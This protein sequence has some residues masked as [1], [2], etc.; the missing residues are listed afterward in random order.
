MPKKRKVAPISQ[1]DH[2]EADNSLYDPQWDAS[3]SSKSF[4]PYAFLSKYFVKQSF[5][6][7]RSTQD[8]S[9]LAGCT[10]TQQ[11]LRPLHRCL[12][13]AK[14]SV[15]E[16]DILADEIRYPRCMK[17]EKVKKFVELV[18]RIQ[19]TMGLSGNALLIQ[20]FSRRRIDP[21]AE[22]TAM[23][24]VIGVYSM[25]ELAFAQRKN[26]V[27]HCLA[28]RDLRLPGYP[29]T[30]NTDIIVLMSI[31]SNWWPCFEDVANPWV[32]CF[33][34]T[35]VDIVTFICLVEA[36][37]SQQERVARKLSLA[38]CSAQ[39]QRRA[40][41][42]PDGPVYGVTLCGFQITMF[43]ATWE[44]NNFTSEDNITHVLS[45]NVLKH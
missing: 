29:W 15:P 14:N 37:F 23:E 18:A 17:D 31:G 43:S 1:E 4:V 27:H 21:L 39:H 38:L 12:Q 11:S 3:D 13:Q 32:F 7:K 25:I 35:S 36:E 40:L 41:G 34:E 20:W 22:P 26:A 5:V 45:P 30:I 28:R 16:F 24:S 6:Q 19:D 10:D 33:M 8:D 44:R 2:N 42:F 9:Y